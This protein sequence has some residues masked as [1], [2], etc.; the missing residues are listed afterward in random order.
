MATR[1]FSTDQFA[2]GKKD[3][4]FGKKSNADFDM[5]WGE[6]EGDSGIPAGGTKGQVL[7]KKTNTDY[8]TEWV[9]P[10]GGGGG[11]LIAN[12]TL[13]NLIPSEGVTQ[14]GVDL[15]VEAISPYKSFCHDVLW[16]GDN[17]FG[18]CEIGYEDDEWYA[19]AVCYDQD[20]GLWDLKPADNVRDSGIITWILQTPAVVSGFSNKNSAFTAD[21][22][23]VSQIRLSLKHAVLR[24]DGESESATLVLDNDDLCAW[25]VFEESGDERTLVFSTS[26]IDNRGDSA[27]FTV[28]VSLTTEG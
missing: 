8:D 7:A 20:N 15:K 13:S 4:V 3:E 11:P 25:E 17:Q 12:V 27:Q 18:G 19:T 16:I 10:Q 6:V 28:D 22:F 1:Q 26:I 21:S 24:W 2:G 23:T 9:T 14:F 5:G